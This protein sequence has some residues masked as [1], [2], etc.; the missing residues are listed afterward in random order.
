MQGASFSQDRRPTEILLHH[1]YF[2]LHGVEVKGG[3]GDGGQCEG[4]RASG[5][6]ARGC[7]EGLDR[8]CSDDRKCLCSSRFIR[9]RTSR[10]EQ[11]DYS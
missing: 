8:T 1:G 9:L 10:R 4:G 11:E 2:Y 7:R 6:R 3:G 5:G